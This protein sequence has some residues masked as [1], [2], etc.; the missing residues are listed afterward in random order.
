MDTNVMVSAL[1]GHGKPRRLLTSLLEGHEIV[2]SRQLLAEL[3]DVLSRDRF[4]F[5]RQQIDGFVSIIIRA[6][7][8]IT[9]EECQETIIEDPDDDVVL[10]TALGEAKY[11]VT[12]DRHLLKLKEYKG[13]MILPV[14]DA[15]DMLA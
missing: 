15:L 13:D 3:E 9:I 1:I 8:V 4:G 7:M 12:G 10:A 2:S 14:N 11:I 5:T 6:S